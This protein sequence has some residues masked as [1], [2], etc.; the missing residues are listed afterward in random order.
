MIPLDGYIVR[1]NEV[2]WRMLDGEAV[3]M[4]EDGSQIHNLNKVASVIWELADEKTTVKQIIE[5]ICEGFDVE[6][7]TAQEDVLEFIQKL[8]DQ[9]LL[10]VN[11]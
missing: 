11:V 4:S 8:V 6:W 9:Q 3:M 10:Q 5:K 2:V 7:N 1:S